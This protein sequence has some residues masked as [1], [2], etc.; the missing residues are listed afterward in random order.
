MG[1]IEVLVSEHRSIQMKMV[2]MEGVC[3]RIETGEAVS[4][5]ELDEFLQFI[6][7]YVDEVHHGKEE[8]YLFPALLAAG[9]P[10]SGGLVN[11]MVTDHRFGE[12]TFEE[13]KQSAAE[14]KMN[15]NGAGARFAESAR[16]YIGQIRKHIDAEN[17]MVFPLIESMVEP[18]KQR[19]ILVQF[20]RLE[21]ER[22]S[23]E[24]SQ[25]YQAL[26]PTARIRG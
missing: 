23:P 12:S 8:I 18:E 1:V 9:M 19:K 20:N 24:Q 10:R 2:V 14:Y 15:R 26:N 11:Q 16:I 4:P 13:M 7:V 3:N 6:S 5:Q 25:A 17:N 21:S 22:L